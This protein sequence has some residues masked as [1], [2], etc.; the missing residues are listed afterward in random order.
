MNSWVALALLLMLLAGPLLWAPLE[1]NIEWFFLALGIVAIATAGP[2][3]AHV[4]WQALSSPI[5]IAAAVVIAGGLF[6]L[7]EKR[8]AQGFNWLA[9]RVPRP[10]LAAAVTLAISTLASIITAIV[11]AL[12]FSLAIKLMEVHERYKAP[13]VVAGCF[14][15]GLGAALLPMGEPLATIAVAALKTGPLGLVRLLGWYVLPGMVFCSLAAGYFAAG[16]RALI[17]GPEQVRAGSSGAFLMQAVRIYAFVAGLVLISEAFA[18]VAQTFIGRLSP[19]QLYW[20][21]MVSAVA[22]NATLVAIEVNG[23]SA[24]RAREALVALLLA[25][26]MLIPGNVPNIICAGQLEIRTRQ[27]ALVGVPMGLALMVVYFLVLRFG[28]LNS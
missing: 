16:P 25:G 11:A 19:T 5:P 10:L 15:I 23:M 3:R 1:H 8:I 24:G 27:W 4:V 22:D 28:S 17:D 20:G 2:I 26:G 7:S 18:P 12:V 9:R 6:V 21:N 14:A 13:T